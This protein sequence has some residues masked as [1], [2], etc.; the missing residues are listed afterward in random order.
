MWNNVVTS[1]VF[2][3]A[4][5]GVYRNNQLDWYLVFVSPGKSKGFYAYL[6]RYAPAACLNCPI[7]PAAQQSQLTLPPYTACPSPVQ[8][9]REWVGATSH[10]KL[11]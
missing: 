2:P 4:V 3:Y 1:F 11:S 6:Q 7:C 8:L 10:T 5:R 9:I